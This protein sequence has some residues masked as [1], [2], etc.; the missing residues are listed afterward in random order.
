MTSSRESVYEN[1]MERT[2]VQTKPK[3]S[4]ALM[5]IE[6]GN[7]R[8]VRV[9]PWKDSLRIDIREWENGKPTKIGVSLTL[10][11]WLTF[12]D[13]IEELEK[14]LRSGK[15]DVRCH[16]GGNVFATVSN[17]YRCVN[18]RQFFKPESQELTA[19]RKGIALRLCEWN[20]LVEYLPSIN[21]AIPNIDTI[22]PCHMQP[23]HSSVQ[24][25]L[26]CSECNPNGF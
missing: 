3:T 14:A 15:I 18:I 25:A 4:E 23:D 8:Y 1:K 17:G 26:M 12:C 16:L 20:T 7:C 22:L 11:R 9:T 13:A 6:L 2:V 24:G 5:E 10:S 21:F 19:T